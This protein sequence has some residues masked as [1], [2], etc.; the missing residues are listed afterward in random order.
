MYRNSQPSRVDLR[1]DPIGAKFK[2]DP[3]RQPSLRHR[4]RLRRRQL[5]T[6]YQSWSVSICPWLFVDCCSWCW[7]YSSMST[8]ASVTESHKLDSISGIATICN[9]YR[10][11]HSIGSFHLMISH[12]S[13][14]IFI[15]FIP[16]RWQKR[17]CKPKFGYLIS[18]VGDNFLSTRGM[19]NFAVLALQICT[20]IRKSFNH[21]VARSFYL[22][23]SHPSV[24]FHFSKK[25]T[26]VIWSQ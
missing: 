10:V 22:V 23:I 25:P 8:T 6:W 3:P 4:S 15:I 24:H 9:R 26:A 12:P 2:V 5:W 18:M 19:S 13:V 14:H 16:L 20:H 7:H 17:I 1:Q 11:G 21:W